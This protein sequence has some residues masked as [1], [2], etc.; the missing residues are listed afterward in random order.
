[1][2]SQVRAEMGFIHELAADL[3]LGL[4]SNTPDMHVSFTVLKHVLQC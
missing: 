3:S 2:Y 1:M 4:G